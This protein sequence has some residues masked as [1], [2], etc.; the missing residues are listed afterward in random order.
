LFVFS[1]EL[2]VC[3]YFASSPDLI[4]GVLVC[5]LL[6]LV[7]CWWNLHHQWPLEM[8]AVYSTGPTICQLPL[9]LLGLLFGC[10]FSHC[11]L[12]LVYCDAFTR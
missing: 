12:P 7:W 9:K 3:S 10:I 4:F 5:R 1:S 6:K 8:S 2:S 11:C